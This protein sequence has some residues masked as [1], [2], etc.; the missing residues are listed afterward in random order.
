MSQE[1][2]DVDHVGGVLGITLDE[3][4]ARNAIGGEMPSEI[5][6]EL[7]RFESDPISRELVVT[8][9]DHLSAPAPM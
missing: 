6:Q 8:G 7:D 3:T 2:I 5:R 1:H 4:P 9:R